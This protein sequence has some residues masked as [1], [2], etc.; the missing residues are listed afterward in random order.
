[1]KLSQATPSDIRNT[2]IDRSSSLS[3]RPYI[4]NVARAIVLDKHAG[5]LTFESEIGKGTTF[6]IRISVDVARAASV[7]SGP[8]PPH[9]PAPEVGT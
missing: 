5:S 8:S 3:G 4:V 2:W 7:E 6:T 1:M 9:T